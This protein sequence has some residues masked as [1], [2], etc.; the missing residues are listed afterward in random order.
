[1]RLAFLCLLVSAMLPSVS[2]AQAPV[3]EI[4]PVEST[5]KF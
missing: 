1:M 3:F 5:I 2:R 4:T